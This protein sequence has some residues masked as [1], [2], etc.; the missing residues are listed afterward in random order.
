VLAA[1]EAYE[2]KAKR[3]RRSKIGLRIVYQSIRFQQKRVRGIESTYDPFL[4]M[5]YYAQGKLLK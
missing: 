3:G 5:V 2:K 1:A 4:P